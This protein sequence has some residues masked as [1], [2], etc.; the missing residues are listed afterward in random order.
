MSVLV[1]DQ[2]IQYQHTIKTIPYAGDTQRFT[3]VQIMLINRNVIGFWLCL[4]N[5]PCRYQ[6]RIR[7]NEIL[8]YTVWVILRHGQCIRYMRNMQP[9]HDSA[10][11]HLV[12]RLLLSRAAAAFKQKAFSIHNRPFFL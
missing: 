7:I 9:L 12:V 4:V 1:D 11:Q 10:C 6:L 5:V 2:I 8:A 3:A